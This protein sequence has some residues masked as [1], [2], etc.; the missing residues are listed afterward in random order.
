MYNWSVDESKLK[1]DPEAYAVWKLEQM[2]NYGTPGERLNKRLI[3]KH[4]DLIRNRIDPQYRDFL[5]LL[6]WPKKK[7]AYSLLIKERLSRR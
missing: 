4:W 3:K 2:I 6:L 7:K 1:H 5:E